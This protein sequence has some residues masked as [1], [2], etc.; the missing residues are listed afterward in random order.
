MKI[1]APDGRV[2]NAED[3]DFKVVKEEWNEYKLDDGTKLKVK[4]VL[5]SVIRTE[6]CDP[7]TGDPVYVIKTGNMLKAIVPDK[8]KKLPSLKESS[9]E[10]VG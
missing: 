3:I 9:G 7:M 6:D 4:L 2:V 1:R 10:E 8:L 5:T